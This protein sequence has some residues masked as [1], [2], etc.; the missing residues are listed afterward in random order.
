ADDPFHDLRVVLGEVGAGEPDVGDQL[1]GRRGGHQHAVA[2]GLLQVVDVG[3]PA[4]AAGDVLVGVE[5]GG[6]LED[7]LGELELHL[8]GL[9]AGVDQRV[10]DEEVRR[11]VLRQHHGLAAQVG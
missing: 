8:G 7:V 3:R 6:R 1:V 11:R 2:A 5:R 4:H 9:Y 10:E